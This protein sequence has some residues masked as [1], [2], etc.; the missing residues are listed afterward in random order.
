MTER[1]M[2]NEGKNLQATSA[3]HAGKFKSET[4]Y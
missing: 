2:K 3:M 4:I 1:K